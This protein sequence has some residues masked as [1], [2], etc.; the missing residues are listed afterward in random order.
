M[1]LT[2]TNA[3][4]LGFYVAWGTFIKPWFHVNY[5]SGNYFLKVYFLAHI[6][7]LKLS[8]LPNSTYYFPGQFY[9]YRAKQNTK[10]ITFISSYFKLRMRIPKCIRSLGII[11]QEILCSMDSQLLVVEHLPCIRPCV[12]NLRDKCE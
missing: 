12:R 9:T 5:V 8:F 11:N 2:I 4:A 10:R 7:D 6:S 1:C 3:A